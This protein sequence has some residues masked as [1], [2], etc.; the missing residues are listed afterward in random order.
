MRTEGVE[1]A[2]SPVEMLELGKRVIDRDPDAAFVDFRGPCVMY[3]IDFDEDP[4]GISRELVAYSDRRHRERLAEQGLAVA[5]VGGLDAALKMAELMRLHAF[6]REFP[7]TLLDPS[8]IA[9]CFGTGGAK[10]QNALRESMLMITQRYV[11]PGAPH[12]D[13]MLAWLDELARRLRGLEGLGWP[14]KRRR[15]WML[16]AMSKWAVELGG[17][18]LDGPEAHGDINRQD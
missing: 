13:E 2:L 10:G 9:H 1:G 16:G 11:E 12:D 7:C 4:D 3:D 18:A 6:D 14:S 17:S 8:A 5:G 15:T